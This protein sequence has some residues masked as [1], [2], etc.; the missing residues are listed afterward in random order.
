[1]AMGQQQAI[2]SDSSGESRC[3]VLEPNGAHYWKTT[4]RVYI[5]LCIVVLGIALG[6][7]FAGFWPIL[8]LAGIELAALGA[9]LYT[10]ARRGVYREL[11][12]IDG[13]HVEIEKGT[14]GPETTWTF[15]LAWSEVVLG[16]PRH[17][18]YPSRLFIRSRGTMV[19]LGAFLTDDD[20]ETLAAELQRCVGPMAT[21]GQHA[22]PPGFSGAG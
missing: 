2:A 19:E 11:V 8:P 22:C 21:K 14:K 17:R 12:R 9:A 5:G 15:D 6:F 13:E 7:T 20:R 10:S 18:W 16:A 3:F 4:L 1:M